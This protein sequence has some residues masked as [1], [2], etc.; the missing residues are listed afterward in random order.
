[1]S[2]FLASFSGHYFGVQGSVTIVVMLPGITDTRL[3]RW[4]QVAMQRHAYFCK[5]AASNLFGCF[6]APCE[7]VTVVHSLYVM[8][9][10]IR[11]PQFEFPKM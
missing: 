8:H 2:L 4:P 1:M 6:V 3:S 10:V 5:A 11:S 9:V 7:S